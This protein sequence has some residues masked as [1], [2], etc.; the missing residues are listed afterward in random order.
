MKKLAALLAFSLCLMMA[1]TAMAAVYF[2]DCTPKES[3]SV[4]ATVNIKKV[5]MSQDTT[6]SERIQKISNEYRLSFIPA[7]NY[8]VF[9]DE[10]SAGST[11]AS[12]YGP[13]R[14]LKDIKE[15]M[16]NKMSSYFEDGAIV[17][18]MFFDAEAEVWATCKESG[19]DKEPIDH[20]HAI[21]V[22]DRTDSHN[23]LVWA[24]SAMGTVDYSYFD[25]PLTGIKMIYSDYNIRSVDGE[26]V[27]FQNTE[28]V[29]IKL[30]N[31]GVQMTFNHLSPVMIAWTE[32]PVSAPLDVPETGDSSS[33]PGLFILLGMSVAAMGA[34]KLRRRE[35]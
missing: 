14:A 35:N 21:N 24:D 13:E 25:G 29:P 12:T 16:L 9:E 19:T 31:A 22:P 8:N 3:F 33:L 20:W 4:P 1:G 34:M 2:E 11:P 6:Y 23:H 10:I 32:A 30:T 15:N 28:E 18:Y 26:Y 5:D 17:K 7:K 27:L